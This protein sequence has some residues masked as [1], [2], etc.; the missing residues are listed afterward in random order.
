MRGTR[1][2][3]SRPMKGEELIHYLQSWCGHLGLSLDYL[4][5]IISYSGVSS[6]ERKAFERIRVSY[7]QDSVLI[8]AEHGPIEKGKDVNSL[9]LSGSLDD[10][11]MQV[12]MGKL[13]KLEPPPSTT[14]VRSATAP[15]R[16]ALQ[17]A[18]P[19]E[20]GTYRILVVTQGRWG[21]RTWSHIISAAPEHWSLSRVA[22]S[23]E[24]PMLIDDASSFLPAEVPGADMVLF[25]SEHP[26][27]MQLLPDLVQMS[28]A[29]AVIAPIDSSSWVPLGEANRV[30]KSLMNMGVASTF[31]RPLCS[32]RETEE[33]ITDEFVRRF[34]APSVE[35]ESYDGRTVGRLIVR[36]GAP[37]GCTDFVAR[38]LEGVPLDEAVARAGLLHH[39]YPCLASMAREDDLGDT[40]MHVSGHELKREVEKEVRKRSGPRPSYLEP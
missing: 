5:I 23:S 17:R 2:E 1:I 19:G 38:G 12:L 18:G 28:G 39:H 25:L 36:R 22:L 14:E 7:G 10:Q 31:P 34:G 8:E 4:P 15:A 40:L 32:L 13:M 30:A 37:C 20:N 27:S 9:R 21:E 24:L 16:K 29:R 26:S 35:L 6:S 33:P 3:L 11:S